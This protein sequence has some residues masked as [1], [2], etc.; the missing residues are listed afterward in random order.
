MKRLLMGIRELSHCWNGAQIRP[1][2][3][4]LYTGTVV[5]FIGIDAGS[6]L[7]FYRE[8]CFACIFKYGLPLSKA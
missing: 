6:Q 5:S 4:K 2:D 7:Q 8:A 3:D 1:M